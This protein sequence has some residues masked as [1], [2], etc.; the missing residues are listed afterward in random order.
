MRART[1]TSRRRPRRFAVVSSAGD[2]ERKKL[3]RRET[4]GVFLNAGRQ[5]KSNAYWS[6]AGCAVSV[7][8][9]PHDDVAGS[10]SG[11]GDLAGVHSGRCCDC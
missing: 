6:D 8:L 2:G 10:V 9:V 5:P 3:P 1:S 7:A 4:S 11:D